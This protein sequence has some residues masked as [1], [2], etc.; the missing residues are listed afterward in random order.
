MS[1][2][3]AAKAGYP[4][5]KFVHKSSKH[6]Y[7]FLN[8]TL[9]NSSFYKNLQAEVKNFNELKVFLKKLDS[10]LRNTSHVAGRALSYLHP[11]ST[12]HWAQTAIPGLVQ[13]G[14]IALTNGVIKIL[15]S[16]DRGRKVGV[17]IPFFKDPAGFLYRLPNNVFSKLQ[18]KI[19]AVQPVIYKWISDTERMT[20]ESIFGRRFMPNRLRSDIKETILKLNKLWHYMSA[21]DVIENRGDGKTYKASIN[22]QL[23]K[24]I[25]LLT[26]YS[27]IGNGSASPGDCHQ[28]QVDRISCLLQKQELLAEKGWVNIKAF[29]LRIAEGEG[30]YFNFEKEMI[31]KIT[32]PIHLA[33]ELARNV[34]EKIKQTIT[35]PKGEFLLLKAN[36]TI[37]DISNFLESIGS[38]FNQHVRV[39]SSD[40]VLFVVPEIRRFEEIIGRLIKIKVKVSLAFLRKLSSFRK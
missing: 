35:S 20:K 11:H 28:L 23:K 15:T 9:Y 40:S 12:K 31:K 5:H 32:S 24:M 30:N 25:D 8:G 22:L 38:F 18:E 17:R 39:K 34:S 10:F 36:E 27:S 37:K 16:L 1:R 4:L 33:K 26:K 6:I 19:S 3:L 14:S 2:F 21:L 29:L 13:N 7:N